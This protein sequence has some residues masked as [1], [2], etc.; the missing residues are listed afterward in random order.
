MMH[1]SVITTGSTSTT[2]IVIKNNNKKTHEMR[3]P[4]K[5]KEKNAKRIELSNFRAQ[6]NESQILLLIHTFTLLQFLRSLP[7]SI[8]NADGNA[9]LF[10]RWRA[11][12]IFLLRD[13]VER[14]LVWKAGM[15]DEIVE[16]EK[17][18]AK[19]CNTFWMDAVEFMHTC[20]CMNGKE[21]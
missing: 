17:E 2:K 11:C 13:T 9:E 4:A 5:Q 1:F 16:R 18:K 6:A 8:P 15:R 12:I 10:N 3:Q 21:Y 19:K 14:T 7:Y 20:L